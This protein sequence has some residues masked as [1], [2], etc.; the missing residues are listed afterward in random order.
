MLIAMY[1]PQLPRWPW[2]LAGVLLLGALGR[3]CDN[4]APPT[5]SGQTPTGLS[6]DSKTTLATIINMNGELC[7][8][9][10]SAEPMG[11]DRY[12]VTCTRYRDGTGTATYELN[13]KTGT[14]K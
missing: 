5:A 9:V 2:V 6:H 12:R 13:A 8:H 14:V 11:A 4:A 10:Q 3:A 7:A 1:P